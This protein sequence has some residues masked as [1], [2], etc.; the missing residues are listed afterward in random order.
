ML[1]GVLSGACAVRAQDRASPDNEA[2]TQLERLIETD[3]NSFTFTPLTV[4]PGR[5]I[6]EVS[7]TYIDIRDALPKHSFPEFITRVGVS[8]RLELRFG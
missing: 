7:Y 4:D 8:R 6:N 1:C 2:D 5:Y 3:R